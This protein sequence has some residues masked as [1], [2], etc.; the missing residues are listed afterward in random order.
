M[1]IGGTS[2]RMGLVAKS[3]EVTALEKYAQEK[4]FH[5]SGNSLA[6]ENADAS[7]NAL[8]ACIE[9]YIQRHIG[10]EKKEGHKKI[11][12][13]AVA[14]P[15]TLNKDKS[16]VLSL[17][18]IVGLDG[19]PLKNMLEKYFSFP[20]FLLKD[21]SALY[22]YDEKRFNLPKEGVVIGCYVGTGFGNAICIDGKLLDGTNGSSGELGHIPLWG[23]GVLCSC[24]NTGCS[25]AVASGAA[26]SRL[27]Q[28]HFP[29]TEIRNMFAEHASHPMLQA[30]VRVLAATIA[31]EI[32]ILDPQTVI[33]GGGVIMMNGF[34][35]ML[36]EEKIREHA[37]KPLPEKNLRFVY[38]DNPGE[39][40][41]AGAGVYGWE[42]RG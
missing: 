13:L 28:E 5:A 29:E 26:L 11:A 21:V 30:F 41:V 16:A 36:L 15:G 12:G 17:P 2:L 1:D 7:V 34:P 18:N 22:H 37:R 25:E 40:G 42:Q 8:C 24:G 6:N 35:K 39:N 20:V 19:K 38:S 27:Q 9:A 3:G 32:N 31:T 10:G 14:L 4:I 23:F 33:L